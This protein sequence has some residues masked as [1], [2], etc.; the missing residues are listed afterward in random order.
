MHPRLVSRRETS[1][2]DC[3]AVL[4]LVASSSPL[5]IGSFMASS[6]L[7]RQFLVTSSQ[8]F[9]TGWSLPPN[10]S[11]LA[12]HHSANFWTRVSSLRKFSGPRIAWLRLRAHC[13][14]RNYTPEVKWHRGFLRDKQMCSAFRPVHETKPFL[15][16]WVLDSSWPMLVSKPL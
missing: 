7:H 5:A 16:A 3:S 10:F 15:Y 11:G 8:I 13:G 14:L 2:C 6:L 4:Q 1:A 12:G 9:L